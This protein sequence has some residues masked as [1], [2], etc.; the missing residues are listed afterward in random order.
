MSEMSQLT[1]SIK[2]ISCD[3]DRII[4]DLC[5]LFKNVASVDT[6][7]LIDSIDK[8]S[9]AAMSTALSSALDPSNK[10]GV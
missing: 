2:N 1:S 3:A 6:K 5:S 4:E 10:N 8:V 7:N 9:S